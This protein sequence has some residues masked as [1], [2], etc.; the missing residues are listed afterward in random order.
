MK[1]RVI[2]GFVFALTGIMCL[3]IGLAIGSRINTTRQ[4]EGINADILKAFPFDLSMM[5][6]HSHGKRDVPANMTPPSL[7]LEILPNMM[8]KGQYSMH[9]I[10]HN[11]RF[12]PEFVNGD[13]V[14]GEGH[15]HLY[16]DGVFIS[17]IYGPWIYIPTL[18]PGK[19]KIYVTLN[20]NNHDEYTVAGKTIGAES[21]V[22]VE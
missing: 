13:P 12:T 1:S 5:G 22:D 19:H 16:I 8:M 11:F 7:K 3:Y 4:I 15:A 2:I 10:L 17:I 18:K 6:T 9:L 21:L 14:F 20:Y